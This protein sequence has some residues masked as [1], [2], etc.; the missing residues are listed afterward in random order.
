[1]EA[2]KVVVRAAGGKEVGGVEAGGNDDSLG[3]KRPVNRASSFVGQHEDKSGAHM[4]GG[5]K[6]ELVSAST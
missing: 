1:M 3:E 4:N 6:K 2:G 5:R